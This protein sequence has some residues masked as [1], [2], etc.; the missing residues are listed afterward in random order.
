MKHK[1]QLQFHS[2]RN[3]RKNRTMVY[4]H[5]PA[6]TDNQKRSYD[7]YQ[8]EIDALSVNLK[9]TKDKTTRKELGDHIRALKSERSSNIDRKQGWT[10]DELY[11][12]TR[13][14]R[15]E[16]LNLNRDAANLTVWDKSLTR[17]ER[18]R[19][20][21][22]RVYL[23]IGSDE[24]D[25]AVWA[26]V[27]IVF[28]R[29]M[30]LGSVVKEAA[31]GREKIGSKYRWNLTLTL[32]YAD[33]QQAM[34]CGVVAIDLGW[35]QETLK[36]ADGRIRVAGVRVKNITGET[37]AEFCLP[38]G[39]DKKLE[40]LNSVKSTLD[41]HTNEAFE[42]IAKWRQSNET[43]PALLDVLNRAE[44]SLRSRKEL[45]RTAPTGHLRSL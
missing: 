16:P 26:S 21:E 23:R 32:R 19:R 42:A 3:V 33:P 22:T 37:F 44:A 30:P 43:P 39:Y 25:G 9:S 35:A 7:S 6:L 36:D 29:P 12:G 1:T 18:R 41:Q 28:H 45:G 38:S 17:A 5:V 27:P 10:E 20:M 14:I 2:I 8:E 40:F 34:N 11:A 13:L 31:V 24:K 15:I 4:Y